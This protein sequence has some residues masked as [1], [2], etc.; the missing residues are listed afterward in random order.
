MNTQTILFVFAAIG[1]L[2]SITR[3]WEFIEKRIE[4][5][6]QNHKQITSVQPFRKLAISFF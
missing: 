1:A 4:I 5:W 2:A 6:K 3:I